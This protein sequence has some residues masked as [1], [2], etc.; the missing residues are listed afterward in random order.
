MDQT[1]QTNITMQTA[2]NLELEEKKE[3]HANIDYKMVAFSLGGKDYAI[4]ILKVKEIAKAERF[5]YVPNTL[6]FVVGVYNL[7]GEIIPIIDLRL[8]FNIEKEEN[9]NNDGNEKDDV[10]LQNMI[11]VN[12]GE[13]KYGVIVDAIERVAGIQSSTIQAPHPLFGDINIKYIYG[14]VEYETRMYILLDIDRIFGVEAA[15]TYEKPEINISTNVVQ[16]KVSNDKKEPPRPRIDEIF[17]NR[18]KVETIQATQELPVEALAQ[19]VSIQEE[20]VTTQEV[21]QKIVEENHEIVDFKFVSET[22]KKHANFHVS[23]INKDW[24]QKRYDRWMSDKETGSVPL[25]DAS[26]VQKFLK[27]FFSTNSAQFWTKEYAQTIYKMLPENTAK[28]IH[29]WNPGCG[30]G[31]EAFS[32]ACLLS[33]KYPEA[34][35]KIHAHDTDLILI[36]SAPLLKVGDEIL[37]T[38]YKPFL[39]K[40]VSGENVF[41][42]RIRDSILFEYHDCT[43]MNTVPM[44]DIIFSRDFL[45]FV[46]E[47]KID[48]ICTDFYDKLKET[49]F[50]I[51]GDNEHFNDGKWNKKMY[52][53][54]VTNTKQ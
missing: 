5:T 16:E 7:R 8:F 18:P 45:S 17:S 41:V 42:P 13:Q 32:L 49:G 34:R 22:L 43:N 52:G 1:L 20:K 46:P 25:N 2:L 35:I 9:E 19:E 37:D 15:D 48:V 11:I 28:N 44:L 6:A 10:D 27:P 51:L 50:V 54:I 36:S 12:I 38:W 40:S 21:E 26:D 53:E 47:N 31:F 39:T 3:Q 23:F 4:D 24:I 29:V 33:K 30:A 14:I